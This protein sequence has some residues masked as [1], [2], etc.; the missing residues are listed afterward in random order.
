MS[1]AADPA[2]GSADPALKCKKVYTS[3]PIRVSWDLRIP[4]GDPRI[5]HK[6]KE[7]LSHLQVF[8]FTLSSIKILL[9]E[10]GTGCDGAGGTTW[11][12]RGGDNRILRGA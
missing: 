10:Q 4:L 3:S 8:A 11:P 12:R 7:A 6:S 5:P 2:A 9:L 1:F